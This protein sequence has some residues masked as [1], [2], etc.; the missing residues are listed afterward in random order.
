V[1]EEAPGAEGIGGGSGLIR[2][3]N[4]PNLA[5]KPRKI[6]DLI[7]DGEVSMSGFGGLLR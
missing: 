5:E 1:G 2:S 3:R 6:P 7:E 4:I